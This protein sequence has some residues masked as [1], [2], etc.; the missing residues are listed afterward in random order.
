MNLSSFFKR[1]FKRKESVGNE[2]P[3]SAQAPKSS[4]LDQESQPAPAGKTSQTCREQILHAC[5]TDDISS[6]RTLFQSLNIT[7]PHPEI[8]Y[9][10]GFQPQPSDPPWTYEMLMTA[11]REQHDRTL[12][13]L[14]K[15]F[16]D[17]K[18]STSVAE[19]GLSHRSIPIWIR[20]LEHDR[21]FL[22][23]EKD[24]SQSTSFSQACWG[25]EPDLP[26]LM[27]EYGADP[28][29]GGFMRM[30]NLTIAMK[31]QPVELIEKLVRKGADLR[32]ELMNAVRYNRVDVVRC[33]LDN[34]VAPEGIHGDIM[35]AA[36]K[37][38]S[39]DIIEILKN[40]G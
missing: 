5:S 25:S 23:N 35:V 12:E 7:A 1:F 20:L 14:L 33:L 8:T 27:L 38:G 10:A 29:I 24:E 6:L 28:N 4:G 39:E 37:V 13:Y 26:L 9:P 3:A 34:G 17:T 11:V 16:P 40:R 19:A 31:E 22:N 2:Q 21:S 30:S 36:E 18:I 32:G 15:V